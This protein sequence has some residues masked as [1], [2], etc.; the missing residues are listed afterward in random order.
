M[1]VG[2]R[3]EHFLV[4]AFG[5]KTAGAE[6]LGAKLSS[7]YKYFR[8]QQEP[9]KVLIRKLTELGCDPMWLQSGEGEMYAAND[10][11]RELRMRVTGDDESPPTYA[12]EAGPD[13]F[14]ARGT[15]STAPPRMP[16]F[17]SPVSAGVPTPS[18]S[19]VERWVGFEDLVPN[20]P[21]TYFVRATGA[22]MLYDGI[23]SGDLL[24]VDKA[25]PAEP[26]RV[27]IASLNGEQVVKRFEKRGKQIWL[28]PAN[29]EF[30]PRMVR[31]G[32][33]FDVLGV[34]VRVIHDL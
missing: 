33:V 31:K 18:G 21:T 29:D 34:V 7:M 20:P 15:E 25:L 9:G 22:S 28:M 6:A 3:V 26:G 12:L 11:G 23:R 32:D 19:D 16:L 13:G 14:T 1:T 4:R 8:G 24:M 5:S 30:E 2:Q 10:A 17:L 27:V